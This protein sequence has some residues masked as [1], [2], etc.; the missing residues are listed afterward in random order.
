MTRPRIILADDHK[1]FA[2]GLKRLLETEFE[3]VAVLEDGESLVSAARELRPD[4]VVADI[5]MPRLNGIEA[6][7]QIMADDPSTKV[8]LLTM[9]EEVS[10]ATTALADGVHGYVL[11]HSDPAE[12]LLAIREALAGRVFVAPALAKDVFRASRSKT[13]TK[14][15]KLTPRQRDI[16]RLLTEGLAAKEIAARLHL[17]RK[18]VEYHK[19][20]MMQNLGLETSAELIRYAIKAGIT[21][22]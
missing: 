20:R 6:A 5:S 17:S 18:T 21:T 12:L 13:A 11:K 15:S 19:Y 7:R 22:A 1:I 4:V 2:A 10:Y 8:V 16:L 3:V 14:E 9:H